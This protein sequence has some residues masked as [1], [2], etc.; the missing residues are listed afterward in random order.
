MPLR[1]DDGERICEQCKQPFA[2]P[3]VRW[4]TKTCSPKCR[5]Q[6][7]RNRKYAEQEAIYT[8]ARAERDKRSKAN[9]RAY[10]KRKKR[11]KASAAKRNK[12]SSRS[13]RRGIIKT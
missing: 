1:N 11:R 9:A 5:Q 12:A 13:R 2:R 4:D 7:H 6:A 10:V 3:N 8:A